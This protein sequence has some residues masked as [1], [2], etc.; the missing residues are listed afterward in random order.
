[1]A[2]KATTD[3]AMILLIGAIATVA[4][5]GIVLSSCQDDVGLAK[6]SRGT[7]AMVADLHAAHAVLVGSDS[8]E[9]YSEAFRVAVHDFDSLVLHN[10]ADSKVRSALSGSVDCMRIARE[11][12]QADEDGAWDTATY[13]S[14]EY[15]R[16]R[17]PSAGID[18][19][20]GELSADEVLDAATRCAEQGLGDAAQMVRE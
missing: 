17:Y 3:S 14:A 1:M 11:A 7:V 18:L 15:W 5:I 16:G 2:R 4:V 9:L 12:W 19:P 13:G 6:P 8:Y 20:S 10:S